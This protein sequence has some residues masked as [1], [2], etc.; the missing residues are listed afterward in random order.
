[1]E[2]PE[3]TDSQ[4]LATW[5][6]RREESA[7]RALVERHGRFVHS[8]ARRAC[9]DE[10][11]A[12]DV[13]Q[14]VFILLAQKAG[15]LTSR[16]SIAGWLH[17]ATLKQAQNVIAKSRREARKLQH[18]Q[19]HME[20]PHTPEPAASWQEIRPQ[21]D[22]ALSA[23]SESDRE[24]L[25]LRFH[26]SMSVKEIAAT[27]G[28]ST[29][30]AQKRLDRATERLREKLT[31]RGVTTAGTLSA[32]MIAGFS[33]DAQAA[34]IST[35]ALST[36]AIAASVVTSTG[37]SSV[38][39]TLFA[40]KATYLPPAIALVLAALWVGNNYLSVKSAEASNEKLEK[41]L[42]PMRSDSTSTADTAVPIRKSNR[43]LKASKP[44]KNIDWREVAKI[45]EDP[46]GNVSLA[47]KYGPTLQTDVESMSLQEIQA[48]M[49]KLDSLELPLNAQ[50]QI[51]ELLF[52][53]LFAK[54]S[55]LARVWLSEQ[56]AK[57]E[58]D[59]K[60]LSGENPRLT[61]FHN[62]VM[63]DLMDHDPAAA[64][65]YMAE[66]SPEHRKSVLMDMHYRNET[67]EQRQMVL[68]LSR[69]FLKEG[70][71]GHVVAIESSAL[72]RS[73]G[74][75]K[76]SEYMKEIGATAIERRSVVTRAALSHIGTARSDG[77]ITREYMDNLRTWI[78][79]EAPEVIGSLTGSSLS[80]ATMG[81]NPMPYAT[82]VEMLLD[83]RKEMPN[84][85]A[86]A[87]FLQFDIAPENV[88]LARS[89]AAQIKNPQMR[90]R[91][92]TKLK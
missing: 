23:L 62:L 42:A 10:A 82:A 68:N 19:T 76:V 45:M 46:E 1:M 43:A 18:F 15:A 70:E 22:S 48:E 83:Y 4:L 71:S 16:T 37:I 38:F 35:S 63:G 11:Q 53:A 60:S 2:L 85:A 61:K 26:R 30:T 79:Q 47:L 77:P 6:A 80:A 56:I 89:V 90:E 24:T 55:K 29:N 84:D 33:A 13:S 41:R 78:R 88:A 92:L 52:K 91:I 69:E 72:V 49:A 51:E 36:K 8:V 7:F 44:F 14:L 39:A 81:E 21:L 25:L 31:R 74:Y 75:A 9:Q 28:L 50:N 54:D 73:E 20:T 3:A 57:G 12:A 59:T 67:A 27:L 34:V 5:L 66:I 64:A 86:L 58:F 17:V 32:V 87:S 40:M 65:A